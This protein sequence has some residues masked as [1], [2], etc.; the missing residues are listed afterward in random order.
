[1]TNHILL[2]TANGLWTLDANGGSPHD[3]F[4]GHSVDALAQDAGR[5]WAIVD[6]KTLRA[7][8]GDREWDAAS[9]D[10]P[11]AT[12]LAA[13]PSGLVVGTEEAHLLRLAGDRLALIESFETATGRESWYTPWGDP[14]DVRSIAV[15]PPVGKAKTGGS[16]R[17]IYVNV[18]V[19]GVVRSTDG[20]RSWTPTVDIEADVHQVIAH[21]TRRGVAL[22]AAAD[23]FG[24]SRDGGDSWEFTTAGLHAHYLR[25]VAI[26]GETVLVSASTGPR[27]KRAAIYRKPLDGR[28]RF[29]RCRAGLPE[30][31]DGNIDTACLAA[32]GR[33][34]VFGTED[35]RVFRSHDGGE[36]WDL[37][38]KGLPGV[39][40]VVIA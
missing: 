15:E 30:W 6:G 35:G 7:T 23:G 32:C 25:A 9:I 10:G 14:A 16:N 21:P 19:G 12:C 39:R 40:S 17:S 11:P 33:L 8:E 4:A 36:S 2:G 5:A 1:M 28:A 29:E 24:E 3:A 38:A 13:T 27:G 26:A 20:G 34:G 31:F 22:V 18:H 37:I